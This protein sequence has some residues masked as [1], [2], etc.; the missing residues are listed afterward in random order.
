MGVVLI[1]CGHCGAP[2][3]AEE[4]ERR[5]TCAY[6]GR[7]Q[8]VTSARAMHQPAGWKAPAQWTPPASA[9]APSIPLRRNPAQAAHKAVRGVLWGVG[10]TVLLSILVPG[11]ILWFVFA[12]T[13]DAVESVA[14]GSGIQLPNMPNVGVGTNASQPIEC[15]T[16]GSVVRTNAQVDVGVGPAV[17]VRNGCQLRLVNTEIR[18]EE[19]IRVEGSGDVTMVNGSITAER[20]AVFA[21]G[22]GTLTLTN[23]ELSGAKGIATEGEARVRTV[24]GGIRAEKVAIEARDTSTV[25]TQ[26]TDLTGEVEQDPSATVRR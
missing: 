24:N 11:V 20:T 19:G 7:Q 8:R 26:N 13:S 1:E 12:K 2:L 21:S 22:D 3:E 10:C 23:V 5:A 14:Q 18:G 25:S 17:V 9:A 16:A 15:V 4:G 6:C